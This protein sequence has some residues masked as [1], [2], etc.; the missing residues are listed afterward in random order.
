METINVQ[1]WLT[2][3][4]HWLITNDFAVG[5]A[6]VVVV[7]AGW[8]LFATRKS[9][10]EIEIVKPLPK[11]EQYRLNR[12]TA[13]ARQRT[14]IA[15]GIGDLL[16]DL[17]SRDELSDDDYKRWNL[18]FGAVVGLAELLP[19]KLTPQDL[20]IAVQKRRGSGFYK[21]RPLKKLEEVIARKPVNPIEAILSKH[22]AQSAGDRNA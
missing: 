7:I 19:Q 11:R 21:Y 2:Y 22:K 3:I 1:Q 8:Y 16:L 4:S 9:Q 13:K 6:V 5:V 17:Y 20:K 12:K 18:R 10:G 15:D 14:L